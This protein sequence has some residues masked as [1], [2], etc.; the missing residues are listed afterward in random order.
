MLRAHALHMRN[1][2]IFV[3]MYVRILGPIAETYYDIS[4]DTY[5]VEIDEN[6]DEIRLWGF[7]S[8][9]KL[10]STD[11]DL[12]FVGLGLQSSSRA[13]LLPDRTSQRRRCMHSS[14]HSG[15]TGEFLFRNLKIL[16]INSISTLHAACPLSCL[17]WCWLMVSVSLPK[18]RD[19]IPVKIPVLMV[20]FRRNCSNFV[21]HR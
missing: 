12:K 16:S 1:A 11:D 7:C 14:L 20:D 21:S 9:T 6:K 8:A 19:L 2:N 15:A 5:A 18:S 10:S 4:A 13:W 17:Y 3:R